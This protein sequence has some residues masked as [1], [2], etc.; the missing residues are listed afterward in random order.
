MTWLFCTLG[1]II[2]AILTGL[3]RAY[4]LKFEVMDLPGA[5]SSHSLPTPRGGGL[6]IVVTLLGLLIVAGFV[7]TLSW[8]QIAALTLPGAMVAAISFVDDHQP[9][10][11]RHRLAVH[12]LA[13]ALALALLP[14]LPAI[15]LGDYTITEPML[16]W[17]ILVLALCWLLNLYNFMDGIDGIAG[18]QAVSV[19]IS[20]AIILFSHGNQ[21]WGENLLWFAAPVAGFLL[22]N[23]APAKIFMGDVGSAYLGITLGIIALITTLYT[24]LN[25]WT[26]VIL[27]AIF[28]VDATWTLLVRFFSGQDWHQPHRTH[29]YQILSRKLNSHAKVSFG[30]VL[31]NGCWLAPL[32][33]LSTRYNEHGLLI[34]VIAC[35][36][37]IALCHTLR[38]GFGSIKKQQQVPVNP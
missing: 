31:I 9:V 12:L 16:L 22:W 8:T 6:A 10:K 34:A 36:P 15:P 14:Q 2:A 18:A 11:N 25:L 4:A 29:S 3:V 27:L 32:A 24:E 20:A 37:L 13:S 26:W 35:L 7:G 38:A 21:F 33:W 28:I 5:R 19:L 17:P 1:L 30:V 23:W